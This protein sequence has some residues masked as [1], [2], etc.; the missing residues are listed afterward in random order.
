VSTKKVPIQDEFPYQLN[1]KDRI[2]AAALALLSP[3]KGDRYILTDGANINKIATY[4]GSTWDY[5]ISLEGWVCW[6]NDE[7]LF[8]E[9]DGSNW[10]SIVPIPSGLI[11]MWS[12]TIATIPSGWYLCNG[13][14]GTPDLR[15]RFIVGAKQDDSGVAKTNVTGALTQSGDG[16]I[17]THS[18][19]V[20][21]EGAHTHTENYDTGTPAYNPQ[22][23][24]N[25]KTCFVVSTQISNNLVVIT[26]VGDAHTHAVTGGG[27]GTTNIAT[28]F[29]LAF[30][31]KA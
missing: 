2:T 29:A 19:T 20:A 27:A 5:L 30:I 10:I 9:Y 1:I 13:S 25:N 3:T 26:G 8:Y 7:D 24:G 31:M 17:P 21:T 28:Y 15:D 6:V 4:N 16:Q 23:T 22:A 12:G 11:A 14:N 18:H